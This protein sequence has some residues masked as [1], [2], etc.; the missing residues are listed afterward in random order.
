ML[1]MDSQFNKLKQAYS[2]NYIQFKVTGDSKYQS[3]YESAKQGLD[4]IISQVS[5]AVKADRKGI[6]DFYKSGVESKLQQS[7]QSN[8]MLK[9]GILEEKD[10][11]TA[12]RLRQNN[13]P[14][15]SSS[16]TTTQWISLGALLVA[17][18]VLS[19]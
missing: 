2:D 13:L 18:L 12:A 4:S 9:Q 10:E 6:S 16:I 1:Q 3:A 7:E 19:M 14:T 15:T 8:R 5:D 11:I 17:S